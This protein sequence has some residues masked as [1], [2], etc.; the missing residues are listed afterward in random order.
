[1]NT[2]RVLL[3]DDDRVSSDAVRE[4][5]EQGGYAVARAAD[6]A[7]GLR[8]ANEFKPDIILLDLILPTTSGIA[9]CAELRRMPIV[10]RAPIVVLTSRDD[11]EHIARAFAAGADDYITKPVRRYELLPRL[12]AHL[13]SKRVLNELEE[14]T[15][16]R[17]LL[18]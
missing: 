17:K 2:P 3:I 16:D 6:G 11:P 10:R 8:L 1:M 18:L 15:R 5:L 7:E 4:L 13:R 14:Q 9:I 12:G